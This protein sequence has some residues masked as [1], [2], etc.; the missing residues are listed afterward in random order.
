M[1]SSSRSLPAPSFHP[2]AL[3]ALALGTL[4]VPV[5]GQG[6]PG[7]GKAG[8]PLRAAV[9]PELKGPGGPVEPALIVLDTSAGAPWSAKQPADVS[10]TGR[11]VGQAVINGQAAG[12]EWTAAGGFQ[13]L[14]GRA[15]S[16]GVGRINSNGDMIFPLNPLVLED[17]TEIWIPNLAGTSGSVELNDVNDDLVVVGRALGSGTTSNVLVWDPVLGS[18]GFFVPNAQD[19]LRRVNQGSLAVGSALFNVNGSDGYVLDLSSG[20]YTLFNGILPPGPTTWSAAIDVSNTGVVVGEGS[21]GM[22]L[23]A[24][25]WTEAGG[26]VFLPGLDG[27]ETTRVHPTAIDDQGRVVGQAMNGAGDWRAFLWDGVDGMRDLNDLVNGP[28]GFVMHRA[29]DISETGVVIGWGTFNGAVL[30]QRGFILDS[31]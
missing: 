3:A 27:G 2:T 5:A 22:S 10:D 13:G 20:D 25:V 15:T 16:T 29:E 4:V 6:S 19:G 28:A 8:V 1:P 23:S 18:R 17:E 7:L 21:D 31:I 24:F 30:P 26:F 12:Y 9:S 11:V 14:T